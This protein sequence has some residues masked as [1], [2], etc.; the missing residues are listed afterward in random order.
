MAITIY[1]NPKCGTSR[2]TLALIRQTGA[3]PMVVEYLRTPLGK[4]QLKALVKKAAV[5]VREIVR[6]KEPLYAEL[7]LD[8]ASDE[9]LYDAMAANPILLNRPIVETD[10]AAKLCRPSELVKDLL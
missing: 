5:P 10:S 9:Q 3:E 7:K 4:A 2:D 6:A 1:H 8:A